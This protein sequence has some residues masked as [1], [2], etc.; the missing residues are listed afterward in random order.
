MKPKYG[1]FVKKWYEELEKG[2][3]MAVKCKHCGSYEFPPIYCCNECGS[4]EMEWVEISGDAYVT[5]MSLMKFHPL[6][7]A[8]EDQ[9][10]K[11]HKP[12]PNKGSVSAAIRLAEGPELNNRV[13]GVDET[14][15][16]ELFKKMPLPVKAFIVQKDGFKTVGFRYTGPGSLLEN[17]Q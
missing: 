2:K 10:A 9:R 8:I 16:D 6:D 12:D 4:T 13:W 1:L 11:E 5:D 17:E 15:K 3:I 7:K 14:N